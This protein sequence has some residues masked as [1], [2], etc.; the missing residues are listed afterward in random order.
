DEQPDGIHIGVGLQVS[1]TSPTSLTSLGIPLF[2]AKKDGGPSVP[3]PFLLGTPKGRIHIATSITI[4]SSPPTPGTARLGAIG[5]DIDVPTA[6]GV[7]VPP[8]FGLSLTGF[9]LPGAQ[10]P[11]DI[12]VAADGLDE[13]DDAVLDLVLSLVRSQADAAAATS[14]IGAIGGLLGLRTGDPI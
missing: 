9:Q 3:S 7:P 1:T 5:L 13:L 14:P 6:P 11:R 12:R 2:I 8:V 10:S 4:D